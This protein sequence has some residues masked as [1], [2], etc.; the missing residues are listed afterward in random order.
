[1]IIPSYEL[2]VLDA[3][4]S[5]MGPFDE[6]TM[7]PKD[8]GTMCKGFAQHCNNIVLLD[9]DASKRSDLLVAAYVQMFCVKITHKETNKAT[10]IIKDFATWPAGLLTDTVE[11]KHERSTL[12]DM[13]CITIIKTIDDYQ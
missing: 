6:G 1:M 8:Y 2:I 10:H 5:L 3:R 9:N 12:Q 4:V 13:H 11:F 7:T